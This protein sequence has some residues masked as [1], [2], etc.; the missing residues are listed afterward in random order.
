[1]NFFR[2]LIR[3]KLP[4]YTGVPFACPMPTDK[5]RFIPAVEAQK[6]SGIKG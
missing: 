1:M 3:R 2:F 6:S 4:A 5:M